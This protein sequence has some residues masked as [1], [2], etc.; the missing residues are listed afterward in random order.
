MM[1]STNIRWMRFKYQ[2]SKRIRYW[3]RLPL[4]IR[5]ELTRHDFRCVS[6]SGTMFC[7]RCWRQVSY[8][9]YKLKYEGEG[10]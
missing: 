2:L 7:N 4:R 9:T 8:K 3:K 6:Y 10:R 1:V 5:C